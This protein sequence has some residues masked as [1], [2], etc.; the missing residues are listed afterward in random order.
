MCGQFRARAALKRRTLERPNLAA[1][2]MWKHTMYFHRLH[3]AAEEGKTLRKQ[4][5]ADLPEAA[6]QAAMNHDF[7][8]H[9]RIVQ[10][11]VPKATDAS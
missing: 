5:T 9:H 8:E 10:A 6:R 11:L 3:R 1:F 7:R 4:R 2:R